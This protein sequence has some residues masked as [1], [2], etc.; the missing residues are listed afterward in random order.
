MLTNKYNLPPPIPEIISEG[1]HEPDPN[2]YSVTDL[3]GPPLIRTLKHKHYNEIAND[4]SDYLW[5]LLGTAVDK[6]LTDSLMSHQ[7]QVKLIREPID[8]C[9]I[10]GVLDVLRDDTIEDWKVTSVYTLSNQDR[11]NEWA[12]QLNMYAWLASEQPDDI[13]IRYIKIHAYLRDWIA[14]KGKYDPKYPKCQ[15]HTLN[16]TPMLLE[17][18]KR[19]EMVLNRLIDHTGNP[20]REC[21]PEEKWQKPTTYAVKAKGAKKAKRVLESQKDA[22]EWI[23]TK[24]ASNLYIEERPG[25]CM[26]CE[27][28]C[29]VAKQCPYYKETHD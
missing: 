21:T 27:S 19:E 23:S 5:M 22:E 17:P 11:I 13:P 3:L 10:V 29:N 28:Y 24:N 26:R 18:V 4:V 16:L 7:A 14:S 1:G 12:S 15:L 9:T 2:R 20:T 8:G 25:G 6:L